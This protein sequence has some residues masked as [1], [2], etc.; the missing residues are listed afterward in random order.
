MMIL[1]KGVF[2]MDKIKGKLARVKREYVYKVMVGDSLLLI[3]SEPSNIQEGGQEPIMAV[4]IK[5]LE[6]V[7][8][9]LFKLVNIDFLDI[10]DDINQ[11]PFLYKIKYKLREVLINKI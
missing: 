6:G 9:D 8:K 4:N 1:K 7:D 11:Y 5:V 10:V 3:K 2:S